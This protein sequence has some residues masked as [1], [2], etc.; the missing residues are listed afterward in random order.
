MPNDDYL[1]EVLGESDTTEENQNMNSQEAIKSGSKM[2]ESQ[3]E[4]GLED[5]IDDFFD[6]VVIDKE[7]L[8]QHMQ[9]RVAKA[10]KEEK[11]IKEEET[12]KAT[13]SASVHIRKKR[14]EEAKD[15][16]NN[17]E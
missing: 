12:M 11:L 9:N 16:V 14:G 15:D 17:D 8:E 5:D 3:G 6:F 10:N 4:F 13:R 7:Q 2:G 1:L